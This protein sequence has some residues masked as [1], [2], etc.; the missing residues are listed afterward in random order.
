V[1]PDRQHRQG[2]LKLQASTC[3]V[4]IRNSNK[5][6][7]DKTLIGRT[8]LP[9]RW[10]LV[11]PAKSDEKTDTLYRF[12]GQRKTGQSNKLTVKE[13][14]ILGE[15]IAIRPADLANSSS[16]AKAGENSRAT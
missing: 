7:E 14:T 13:E 8:S 16:T 15:E 3:H 5:G 6:D 4:G 11:E 9:P 10:K 12:K 2:R 1:A